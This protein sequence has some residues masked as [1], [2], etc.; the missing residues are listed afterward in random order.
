MLNYKDYVLQIFKNNYSSLNDFILTWAVIN[1]DTGLLLLINDLS[2]RA[3]AARC[4]VVMTH[5][6]RVR[7]SMRA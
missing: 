5:N 4:I 3:R 2:F 6:V 7:A 1:I